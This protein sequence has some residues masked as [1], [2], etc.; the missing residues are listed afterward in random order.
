MRDSM[1]VVGMAGAHCMGVRA[2]LF[3]STWAGPLLVW[4]SRSSSSL[5][6]GRAGAGA[7]AFAGLL[8]LLS[9]RLLLRF[10]CR[11]AGA[12]FCPLSPVAC[13]GASLDFALLRER[14]SR[15]AAYSAVKSPLGSA[16]LASLVLSFGR[17][18]SVGID[19]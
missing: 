18:S 3:V 8:G 1:L 14:G 16:S 5:L 4:S 6:V 17:S 12:S 10:E 19:P 9:L 7:L 2:V 13:I 15:I 11:I